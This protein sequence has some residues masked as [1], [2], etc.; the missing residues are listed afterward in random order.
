MADHSCAATCGR[1]WAILQNP[2]SPLDLWFV[3]AVFPAIRPPL[4]RSSCR[5]RREES[6]VKEIQNL[7]ERGVCWNFFVTTVISIVGVFCASAPLTSDVGILIFVTSALAAVILS[8]IWHYGYG[9]GGSLL[10]IAFA[11][12]LSYIVFW[13]IVR[14][15]DNAPA[16]LRH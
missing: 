5:T 4:D 15:R 2:G 14:P 1:F 9:I 10:S 13:I 11:L 3:P 8:F 6:N 7:L 16:T 12:G